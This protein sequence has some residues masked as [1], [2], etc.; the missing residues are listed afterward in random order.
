M[1]AKKKK[2]AIRSK[3]APTVPNN[4]PA[5]KPMRIKGSQRILNEI[6]KYQKSTDLLIRKLPFA[7]LVKEITESV[8]REPLRWQGVAIDALQEASEAYLVGL[9]E[10]GMLCAIHGKR[11]T[12]M[13]RDIQLSLRIRN[14]ERY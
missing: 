3:D 6:R 1:E 12:L 7:R 2:P 9:L 11:V 4:K 5:K 13:T 10:D 14:A 8:S